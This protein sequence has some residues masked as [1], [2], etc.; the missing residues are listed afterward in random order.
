MPNTGIHRNGLPLCF[1]YAGSG[2]DAV[3]AQ[4]VVLLG[5]VVEELD[6]LDA[7]ELVTGWREPMG[8]WEWAARWQQ[9]MGWN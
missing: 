9:T 4:Y 1:S 5:H 2:A 8:R 3:R 6:W 7:R